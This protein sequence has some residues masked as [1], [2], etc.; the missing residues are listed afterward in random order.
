M[1]DII[2]ATKININGTIIVIAT[3]ANLGFLGSSAIVLPKS[4]GFSHLLQAAASMEPE[5]V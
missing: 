2:I 4:A 5:L 3:M 1:T